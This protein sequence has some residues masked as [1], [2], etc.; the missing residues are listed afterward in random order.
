MSKQE[1]PN[2]FREEGDGPETGNQA[3]VEDRECLR[4]QV[5]EEIGRQFPGLEHDVVLKRAFRIT[6]DLAGAQDVQQTFYLGLLRLSTD[7]RA[8]IRSLDAYI[9]D[10]VRNLALRWRKKHQPSN[11]K[12]LGAEFNEEKVDDVAERVA[13]ENEIN[14]MLNHL[15]EDCREGFV[16]Y[17]AEGCTAKEAA[18]RLGISVEAFKKRLQRSFLILTE[19]RIAYEERRK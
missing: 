18:A 8:A 10:S 16:Y 6:R 13:E 1:S 11:H 15:P 12:G 9:S 3:T 4:R 14:F 5:A 19:A 2:S 17:V 7:Q